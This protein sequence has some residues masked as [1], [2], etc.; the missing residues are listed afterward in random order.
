MRKSRSEARVKSHPKR[1]W[2]IIQINLKIW[3]RKKMP[4]IHFHL[5][6]SG[7]DGLMTFCS[8]VIFYVQKSI[9]ILFFYF[10]FLMLPWVFCLL[11]RSSQ[12]HFWRYS[13]LKHSQIENFNVLYANNFQKD[14][15]RSLNLFIRRSCMT[16]IFV[17]INWSCEG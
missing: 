12:S 3:K 8:C 7:L 13:S 6:G 14:H 9:L 4:Q 10:A 16:D 15:T 2:K 11:L 5:N 17:R 1:R